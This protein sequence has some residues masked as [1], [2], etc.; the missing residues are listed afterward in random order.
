M[1]RKKKRPQL[2]I[3]FTF[4]LPFF[5]QCHCFISYTSSPCCVAYSDGDWGWKTVNNISS[6][7][8]LHS[9]TFLCSSVQPV[10][11]VIVLSSSVPSWGPFPLLLHLWH[12]WSQGFALYSLTTT[13]YWLLP[14]FKYGW[15]AQP[16]PEVCPLELTGTSRVQFG[17]AL[18]YPCRGSPCS[19]PTTK[20]LTPTSNKQLCERQ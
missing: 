11:Q 19:S 1:L 3:H 14:L 5:I 4:H 20:T 10:P 8:V 18:P 15:W 17:A 12:W 6:L 7:M 13:A 16:C 9:H 2:K